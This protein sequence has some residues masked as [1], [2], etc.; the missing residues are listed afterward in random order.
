MID[1]IIDS[2]YSTPLLGILVI[3]ILLWIFYNSYLLIKKVIN[4]SIKK[5]T[6]FSEKNKKNDYVLSK[7]IH[8]FIFFI[9][10][11]IIFLFW[12]SNDFFIIIFIE[13]LSIVFWLMIFTLSIT[14]YKKH[15][16][17]KKNIDVLHIS[18]KTYNIFFILI[19]LWFSFSSLT[20]YSKNQTIGDVPSNDINEIVIFSEE[21]LNDDKPYH[22]ER[23]VDWKEGIKYRFK[24]DSIKYVAYFKNSKI[25]SVWEYNPYR[26]RIYEINY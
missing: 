19:I 15:E 18:I 9:I 1:L 6:Q 22:I 14:N 12:A 26:E 8:I 17:N 13:Y 10:T 5:S 7:K 24:V 3:F 11:F 2:P 21:H 20:Y 16:E 4:Y 23:T 25:I